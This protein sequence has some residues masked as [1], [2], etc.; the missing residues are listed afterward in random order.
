MS[1]VITGRPGLHADECWKKGRPLVDMS[2]A[3]IPWHWRV[4]FWFLT[5]IMGIWEGAC[6]IPLLLVVSVMG[7]LPSFQFQATLKSAVRWCV[8]CYNDH[9][10]VAWRASGYS[11]PG[12]YVP[13]HLV[14]SWAAVVGSSGH[15]LRVRAKAVDG[16]DFQPTWP[17]TCW[18]SAEYCVAGPGIDQ[19]CSTAGQSTWGRDRKKE[20]CYLLCI[21]RERLWLS[22]GASPLHAEVPWFSLQG[23]QLKG[24]ASKWQ[25][26][27]EPQLARADNIAL[28]ILML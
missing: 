9:H 27:E 6:P 22:G 17:C 18:S 23:L 20:H 2:Q 28:G 7:G 12:W 24:S 11:A 4:A 5:F 15:I 3:F 25:G 16:W 8:C 26:P 10:E 13:V 1:S 14:S 19:L 21:V